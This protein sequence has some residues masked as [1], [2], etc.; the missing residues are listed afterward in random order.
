ME[1]ISLNNIEYSILQKWERITI[2]DSFVVSQ[3]KIGTGN[4]E[5]KLYIGQNDSYLIDF[6]GTR[7]FSINCVLLKEDLLRYLKDVEIEYLAPSQNYR[8]KALLPQLYS[9]RLEIVQALN[10]E[11]EFCLIDQDQIIGPR[12]YVSSL[13]R[14]YQLL[15]E[16]SLPGISY[17]TVYKVQNTS[18][19]SL[20]KFYITLNAELEER[21]IDP[22]IGNENTFIVSP[23]D[24]NKI[25]VRTLPSTIGQI[26]DDLQDNII[27]LDTEFQRLPNLWDDKKKSRFIE[28]LLLKLPIPAFYFN[29]REENDL[30][31]VDGLQ[32]ISTIKSFAVDYK[33]VLKDL[34]FLKEYNGFT[35]NSLPSLFTRRIKT[36]PITTYVIEKGTPNEVKYNIFKRVNTGGLVLTPQEIRHAINNGI[37][38]DL[39]ADLVRGE[40]ILDDSKELAKRK[41]HDG[42][43]ID[44]KATP[45]GKAFVTA[46]DD[47]IGR[48]RMEDR[49]FA[50][51]FIS[52][53]VIPFNKYEP[54]LDTFLN[55]GMSRIK[56]LSK[57][58]IVLL[59]DNFRKSMDLS[60]QIFGKDAFRKRFNIYDSRKPINKALFEVLSVT[61]AL[62][63][64]KERVDLLRK[65]EDF[66]IKLIEL[67]NFSDGKFLRSITQGTAQKDSVE[68]RF[69]D[70]SR[71]IKETLNND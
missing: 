27:N 11:T 24:P 62:L 55:K 9:E 41:N 28:S 26:I 46:T 40:D 2:A 7:G 14:D 60:F 34:E 47:R 12:V 19:S 35:Y 61:F 65:K 36:F 31:V 1:S 39:V 49:D 30:E 23:F 20:I 15:R 58:E 54:D 4:G 52:F 45:E 6:F 32:R 18:D 64:D 50:T 16:L 17:L 70:I 44:L 43:I 68:Q 38:S 25:K 37:A 13:D 10:N 22:E 59:K 33:L 42:C 53:Y 5:S 48:F 71:I 21:A 51:R 29:E 69:T 56:D 66:K 8:N 67:H 63:S 57:Q 3:N